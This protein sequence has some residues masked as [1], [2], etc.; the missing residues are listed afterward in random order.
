MAITFDKYN[1][2]VG[3]ITRSDLTPDGLAQTMLEKGKRHEQHVSASDGCAKSTVSPQ[4]QYFVFHFFF[5]RSDQV[6]W[7]RDAYKVTVYCKLTAILPI[8][9]QYG[10]DNHVSNQ[11]D[12]QLAQHR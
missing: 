4:A 5:G 7:T 2:V 9:T 11:T 10:P 8:V 12:F 6:W 3:T 1:Q